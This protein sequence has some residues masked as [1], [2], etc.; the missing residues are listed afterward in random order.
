MRVRIAVIASMVASPGLTQAR[1]ASSHLNSEAHLPGAPGQTVEGIGAPGLNQVGGFAVTVETNGS[2]GPLS[3]VW[4][5]SH[6]APGLS[7]A[8]GFTIQP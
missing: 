1:V 8:V 7:N 6:G 4:G 3:Y 5:S 2:A